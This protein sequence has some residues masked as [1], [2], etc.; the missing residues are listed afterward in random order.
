[1]TEEPQCYNEGC[2]QKAVYITGDNKYICQRHKDE[3]QTFVD[4]R[5]FGG[6]VNAKRI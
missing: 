1:M 5:S 4:T 6:K 2:N 3:W